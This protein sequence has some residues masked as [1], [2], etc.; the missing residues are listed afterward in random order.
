MTYGQEK[1]T[2]HAQYRESLKS[3]FYWLKKMTQTPQ[4]KDKLTDD[5]FDWNESE[6]IPLFLEN[7]TT[8]IPEQTLPLAPIQAKPTSLVSATTTTQNNGEESSWWNRQS[9]RFKSAL[10]ATVL[11][12]IPVIF[13]GGIVYQ[14]ANANLAKIETKRPVELQEQKNN[15]FWLYLWTSGLSIAAIAYASKLIFDNLFKPIVQTSQTVERIGQGNLKL[16]LPIEG[17]NE[18]SLLNQNINTM[19]SGIQN[20]LT[21]K[22]QSLQKTQFLANITGSKVTDSSSLERLIGQMLEGLR[23]FYQADRVVLYRVNY[24]GGGVTHESIAPGWPSALNQ[25]IMLNDSCIPEELLRSYENGRIVPTNDVLSANWHPEH[26]NLMEQLKIKSNLVVPILDTGK[27]HSLLILHHCKEIHIWQ[28]YEINFLTAVSEEFSTVISRL[29]SQERRIQEAVR[30]QKLKDITVTIAN[31]TNTKEVYEIATKEV[32]S[33][34]N[35]DRVIIYKFDPAWGG[36]IITEATTGV[37]PTTLNAQIDDPCFA[38]DYVEKYRNGRV[39][40]LANIYKAGLTKCYLKQLEPYQVIANIVAPIVGRGELT[41]LLIAH[42]CSGPREWEDGE[43]EFFGQLATQ[44]GLAAEKTELLQ[45]RAISETEQRV[46]K[47]QLQKRALE[48]LMQVDPV[49]QGDLTIRATVTEDEIGTIADSF[50]ATVENLRK[51]VNQVQMAVRQVASTAIEKEVSVRG[52]SGEALTQAQNIATA[53]QSIQ[54]MTE[55]IRLVAANA[56]KAEIFVQAANKTV[57]SGEEAMN[58]T[59]NSIMSIRETV[60]ET[61]KKVKRLGES[62]QKISKVVN[63][64]SSFADQTNLLALNA[65]I[66]AAHAGEEGRGFAVVA[67]EVRSLA[68]QSA[69]ATAEIETLVATI[70]AETNEVVSAME[71]GTEQVVTGTKLVE[72]TRQS[73]NQITAASQEINQLVEAISNS[74]MEQVETSQTVTEVMESVALLSD[75]TSIEANQ[76]LVSF[77]QMR[78]VAQSLQESVS[79]F[80]V[81]KN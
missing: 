62:S 63:L 74:A 56:E 81:E 19:T 40:A 60:A 6:I 76:V 80:K 68:R 59:V 18:V 51:L 26:L 22:S 24:N 55:S 20:L 71:A 65:S 17:Q 41:A 67:E 14:M 15:L 8:S 61:A 79:K 34:L 58:R 52:L 54:K 43:V 11:G 13:A 47:E 27:I 33:A 30:A 1:Q 75:K 66:E 38:Q 72:E 49:S 57:E 28:D 46:G 9:L 21:T 37:Y 78:E 69:Q 42:Q 77:E 64:I 35:V 23:G 10:I 7:E 50:N 16:R 31:A 44:V 36:K 3:T 39:K 32:R 5:S 4:K 70:Q 12:S 53:L 25:W 48:L 2:I 29:G 45:Q 73:L